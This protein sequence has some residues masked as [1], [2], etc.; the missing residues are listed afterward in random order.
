MKKFI[1]MNLTILSIIL[2]IPGLVMAQ[3]PGIKKQPPLKPPPRQARNSMEDALPEV[4]TAVRSETELKRSARFTHLTTE[5]GLAHNH[6][7]VMMQDSHRFMWIGTGGGLNR[8]DGYGFTTYTHDPDN[9]NSLSGNR[10]HDL[11]EDHSGRIWIA[12][13]ETGFGR[14]DPQT[15][16][17]IRYFADPE[18]PTSSDNSAFSIYQDTSG[19]LWFGGIH[20]SLTRFDPTTEIMT[21]Y[22]IDFKIPPGGPPTP[23]WE[24][25]EDR[26]GQLWLAATLAL[27]QFNPQTGQMIHHVPPD[28]PGEIRSVYEDSTGALW[29]TAEVLYKFDPDTQQFTRYPV[30]EHP[31]MRVIADQSGNLWLG[32]LD[33]LFRFDPHTEQ[34]THH[35]AQSPG[36]G[37]SL[38]SNRIFSLYEDAENM[39]WIGTEDAGVSILNPHQQQFVHHQLI[40]QQSG[41]VTANEITAMT[42][43]E[44]GELWFSTRNGLIRFHSISGDLISYGFPSQL[45]FCPF[46]IQAIARDP[47]GMVWFSM[48]EFLY[49][50]EETSETLTKY[51]LLDTVPQ[52]GPPPRILS[53]AADRDGTLWLAIWRTGFFRFD[54]RTGAFQRYRSDP[55]NPHSIESEHITSVSGDG[56]KGIWAAG[57]RLLS[58]FEPHTGQFHNYPAPIDEVHMIHEDR[59]GDV[60]I[61]AGNGLFRFDHT[62]ETFALYTKGIPGT[63]VMG[64]LEDNAG[65]LWLSTTRGLVG[66]DIGAETFRA[67]DIDDGVG[68]NEFHAGAAWKGA[69]GRLFFGGKHGLT[70]FYPDR[71]KDNPYRP[72]V[73]LTELRL[74]NEPVPIGEDSLLQQPIWEIDHLSLNYKQS[75]ISFEFAALSYSAPHKNRYRYMLEGLEK[76]WNTVDSTRRFATYTDLDAGNYIFR[77]Q[78]SNNSGVWSDQ[79]VALSID[80]LPPWWEAVWLRAA[81][82][83]IIAG[84]LFSLYRWR[85]SKIKAENARKFAETANQSKSEFLANMS[86][87][88]RTPMNAIIGLS[89]L[90]L[91]TRLTPKQLDYQEKIHGSAN[92]LLRLINDILDFSKIEAGKLDLEIMDFE[93]PEMLESLSSVINVKAKEKG[94]NFSTHIGESV[95]LRITGDLLRLNQ[96]LMNL[97]SNA[98]K[99]THQGEVTVIADLVELL[100]QEVILRFTV[101]DTGIGMTGEQIENLFQPFHQADSSIT[102]KFGG[103]G[104]GLAISMQLIEMMGGEIQVESESESGTRFFFTVRLGIST[105]TAPLNTDVVPVEQAFTLLE[106]CHILLADD[107]EI[108]MQVG[109]ELLMQAGVRV[110]EA[111]NGREAVNMVRN[112]RFDAVLMDLQ[113]PVMDGFAAART[114]RNGPGPKELPIIAMTANAMAGDREKCLTSGMNDHIAKPIKPAALYETLIRWIKPDVDLTHSRVPLSDSNSNAPETIDFPALDGVDIKAGLANVNGDRKLFLK[115]LENMYA[116][117]RDFDQ[118]IQAEMDCGD[119]ETAQRSAHTIKGVSG[120]LGALILQ[121]QSLNLESAIKN[122]EI[123]R[124]PDLMIFFSEELSRV[125]KAL[126][127][128]FPPKNPEIA[129]PV[130]IDLMPETLNMEKLKAIFKDLSQLIDEGKFDALQLLQQLKEELGPSG[131]TE[132]ILKLESLLNDYDFDEARCAARQISNTLW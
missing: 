99:F 43:D 98:V 62:A 14:F 122:K 31:I 81:I 20:G 10:I 130:Q 40:S 82:L 52:Q 47:S 129:E 17:F 95:P 96:V 32:T 74:F 65:A 30:T 108:N 112:K 69:D 49:R 72:P 121:Q 126:E 56:A 110:T 57:P 84:V 29:I 41:R 78:A 24:I 132:D 8:F 131:V 1:I 22:S 59:T 26:S 39:I 46:G 103:T 107:N 119:F 80:V 61:A 33:G 60:W 38:S 28:K 77:V 90:T 19:M 7:E 120:T 123:D 85:I 102:R 127:P 58:R 92:S 88:I 91:Q 12:Y 104:L 73:V 37:G 18:H 79:E 9:P 16:T 124:I 63:S 27:I 101:S 13:G 53:I 114:I 113:M 125:M 83:L 44:S 45:P 105:T 51:A 36:N 75:I 76:K 6:V 35:Y 111:I 4:E 66:F 128:L 42:G 117:F 23:I 116:R 70:A 21:S 94:L 115:V 54:P 86:H 55:G 3:E 106:G 67:Y 25:I 2:S 15:D 64:I 11:L 34:V 118:K 87:E 93:L 5:N 89:Y 50:F 100:D 97:A 109:S 71:I 48:C 68:G